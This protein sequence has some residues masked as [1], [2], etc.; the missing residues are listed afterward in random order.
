VDRTEVASDENNITVQGIREKS[1]TESAMEAKLA[2]GWIAGKFD[3]AL[4]RGLGKSARNSNATLP[5]R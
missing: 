4:L 2:Y 3:D 1:Q 5:M